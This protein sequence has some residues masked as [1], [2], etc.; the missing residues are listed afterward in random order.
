[1]TRAEIEKM[2]GIAIEEGPGPAAPAVPANNAGINAPVVR[3]NPYA[4]PTTPNPLSNERNYIPPV[5]RAEG[6]PPEGEKPLK[7]RVVGWMRDTEKA[8][9]K[10]L[11][12]MEIRNYAT[13]RPKELGLKGEEGGDADAMRHLLL[14]REMRTKF[15]RTAGGMLWAHEAVFSNP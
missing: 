8:V 6:S 12:L 3:D 7:D 4:M 15:P 9:S 13:N 11:G 10:P 1:M 5:T 14:A 2:G